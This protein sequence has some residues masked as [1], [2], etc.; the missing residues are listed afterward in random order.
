MREHHDIIIIGAGLSGLYSAWQLHQKQQDVI[1]LET[2]NRTGGRIFSAEYDKTCRFDMGP[3]WVWPALQPRLQQLITHLNLNVFKQFTSGDMLY[4]KTST[5]VER[6]SGQSSHSQSYRIAG[7]S[8][9]LIDALQ[10][11]IPLSCIHL[12]TCVQSIHQTDLCIHT[13]RDGRPCEYTAN[14]IILALPPRL[15]QQNIA[16]DPPF[17]KDITEAWSDI[18]T[19]MS[20]HSKIVFIYEKP[21]WREQN[22]SGE[23]FSHFG[24]LSEIYDAT[25]VNEEYYAL[26]SFVGLNAQQRNQM[27]PEQLIEACMAQLQRLFGEDSKNILDSKIKDWSQDKNTSTAIDLTSP[28]QHP[29]YP[30]AM[31]RSF[32]NKKKLIVSGTEVA[33]QH[34]GYLEGAL[35]SADEA[36]S[37]CES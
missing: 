15:T 3:A 37:L 24:P 1:V 33:R 31:P 34:G 11:N 18:P 29:H 32:W 25:P 14:K 7:G 27:R 26:T 6:H 12:N 21:F 19:W 30:D 2:R 10:S 22:L 9:S 23:V 20:G 35:E 4:E 28:M 13:L 36:I 8:Q 5:E 16:F 17:S